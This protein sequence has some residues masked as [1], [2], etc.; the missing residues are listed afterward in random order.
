MTAV[1]SSDNL[2]WPT[3]LASK[4][5]RD[6]CQQHP[7]ATMTGPRPLPRSSVT[8]CR[9]RATPRVSGALT[10][11]MIARR[12]GPEDR[13]GQVPHGV[14]GFSKCHVR[15]HQRRAAPA[16]VEPQDV[17]MLDSPSVPGCT[18]GSKHSPA[19]GSKLACNPIC[20]CKQCSTATSPTCY[21]C[22]ATS[23]C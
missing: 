16:V 3:S 5:L 13:Q 7:P 2:F 19:P 14:A 6:L 4:G 1:Q 9:A 10:L 17:Q 21:A 11:I 18:N 15:L 22:Q 20:C 8:D 23:Q 12:L